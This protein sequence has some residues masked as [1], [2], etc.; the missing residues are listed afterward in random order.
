M[1]V[2]DAKECDVEKIKLLINLRKITQLVIYK[3]NFLGKKYMLLKIMD[4]L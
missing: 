3:D 2:R 1:I 4:V